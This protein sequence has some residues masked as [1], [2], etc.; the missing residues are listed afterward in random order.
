MTI[1]TPADLV[2][3]D[4]AHIAQRLA[5]ATTRVT[6][7][8]RADLAHPRSVAVARS[9]SSKSAAFWSIR[10]RMVRRS[11]PDCVDDGIQRGFVRVVGGVPHAIR[12]SLWEAA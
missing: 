10:G 8:R 6:K 12:G 2:T 3:V 7:R 4:G 1:D 11:G 5:L 9:T